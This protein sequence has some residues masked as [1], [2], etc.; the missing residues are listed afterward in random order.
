MFIFNLKVLEFDIKYMSES[1]Y[2][3]EYISMNKADIIPNIT[4]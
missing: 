3:A 2:N 4:S 1:M